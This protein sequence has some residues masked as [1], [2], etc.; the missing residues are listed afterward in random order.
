MKKVEAVALFG[1]VGKAAAAMGCTR[2]AVHSWQEELTLG[3]ADRVIGA[4]LRM[5][6][7][8]MRQAEILMDRRYT[9]KPVKIK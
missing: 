7:T 1:G 3:Q 8:T 5:G 2:Q 6:M 4:A 9:G